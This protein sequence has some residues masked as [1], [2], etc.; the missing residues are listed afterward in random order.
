[1]AH[2]GASPAA[3][4]T[5][6]YLCRIDI[7]HPKVSEQPIN[8][9]H[10]ACRQDKNP[11]RT[12]DFVD[13]HTNDYM[14]VRRLRRDRLGNLTAVAHQNCSAVVSK[15]VKSRRRRR[16]LAYQR[17]YRDEAIRIMGLL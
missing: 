7:F 14:S 17:I 15:I 5:A 9:P 3:S 16:G 11:P 2:L 6:E 12:V 8:R 1:M 13:K 10:A 4:L